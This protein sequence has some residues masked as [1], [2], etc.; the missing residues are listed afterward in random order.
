MKC[1]NHP[2]K[3]AIGVCVCCGKALCQQCRNFERGKIFCSE[4]HNE[5]FFD[6]FDFT[7]GFR[8]FGKAMKE[9]AFTIDKCPK[10]GKLI[11]HDFLI[12]PYCSVNLRTKCKNCGKTVEKNWIACPF[13]AAKLEN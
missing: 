2:K 13:C 3:E 11:K 8:D 7:F 9:W 10:C 12:C 4:C 1:F 5:S 6:T